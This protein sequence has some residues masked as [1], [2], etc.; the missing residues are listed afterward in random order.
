MI[1]QTFIG[2]ALRDL[3][4]FVQFAKREKHPEGV[5][6]LVRLLAFSLQLY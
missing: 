4:L 1:L 3:V 6:L 5:L 2:D